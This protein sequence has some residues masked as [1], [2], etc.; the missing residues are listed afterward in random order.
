MTEFLPYSNI[1]IIFQITT[2]LLVSIILYFTIKAYKITNQ[3]FLLT[4]M[5]G[6]V[7]LEISV[8]FVLLNRLFGQTAIIYHSTFWIQATL[9]TAAFC[10]IALSYY[11]RNRNLSIRR[12]ATFIFILV[13][14]LSVSLVFFSYLLTTATLSH[15]RITLSI[16]MYSVNLG[17]LAYIVYNL[18]NTTF[19]KAKKRTKIVSDIFIP[20]GFITLTIGQ[21]LW[22]YWGFTDTNISL[23]LANLSLAV[24][25]GF[26]T[27]SLLR[28]WRNG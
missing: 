12:I 22:I 11:F 13:G 15:W 18:Y 14:V 28:I 1:F 20:L 8:A 19:S 16:Y 21:I 25:L 4:F 9:Q 5:I 27:A 10:F 2:V 6:F 23:V 7:F 3:N 17:I 26:L 24:G